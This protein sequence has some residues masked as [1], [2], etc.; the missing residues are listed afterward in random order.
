[1]SGIIDV[2]TGFMLLV[3]PYSSAQVMPVESLTLEQQLAQYP[4]FNQL[5]AQAQAQLLSELQKQQQALSQGIQLITLPTL[6]SPGTATGSS[7]SPD[8]QSQTTASISVNS[9][10]KTRPLS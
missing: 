10:R 8:S 4:L 7:P 3:P 6:G 5:T 9:V 1:M 2:Q